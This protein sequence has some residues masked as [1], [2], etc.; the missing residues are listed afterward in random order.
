MNEESRALNV[1]SAFRSGDGRGVRVALLDS[2]VERLHP[3]FK[4]VTFAD[5]LCFT[6]TEN[7]TFVFLPLLVTRGL[8]ISA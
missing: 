5:D 4:N 1:P 3:E 6:M 7:G 2:G 8:R